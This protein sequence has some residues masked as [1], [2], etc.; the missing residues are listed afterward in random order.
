MNAIQRKLNSNKGS[1]ILL[2]M[3]LVLICVMVS[4]VVITAASSGSSRN[5]ERIKSQQAYLAV[6]SAADLLMDEMKNIGTYIGNHEVINYGCKKYTTD[7]IQGVLKDKEGHEKQGYK[8][9]DLV[10]GASSVLLNEINT[11]GTVCLA[12]SAVENN[13]KMTNE[14]ETLMHQGALGTIVKTAAEEIYTK[15]AFIPPYKRT[16]TIEVNDERLPKVVCEFSMS[17]EYDIEMKL[18]TEDGLY[19]M[20]ITAQGHQETG[21]PVETIDTSKTCTHEVYYSV[22]KN[23]AFI[24]DEGQKTIS[25]TKKTYKTSVTWDGVEMKKGE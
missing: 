18:Q 1:S 23:G 21:E 17:A 12:E 13:I 2:A 25:A 10:A 16:F 7:G 8:A 24:Y 20:T 11:S 9:D 4:S 19:A 5:K 6:S 14:T 15:D 22:L 3:S